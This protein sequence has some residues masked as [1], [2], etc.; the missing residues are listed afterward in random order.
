[1][2]SDG[3]ITPLRAVQ[4]DLEGKGSIGNIVVAE[5]IDAMQ[6]RLSHLGEVEVDD[7]VDR[8]DVDSASEQI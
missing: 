5:A 4:L 6:V 7:N 3:R 1:V 2:R 8:L